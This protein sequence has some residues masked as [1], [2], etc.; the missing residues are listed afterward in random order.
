[1]LSEKDKRAGGRPAGKA[2]HDPSG[3]CRARAARL[4]GDRQP[5]QSADVASSPTKLALQGLTLLV[6][7]RHRER[8]LQRLDL[9][10]TAF[11]N[12]RSGINEMHGPSVTPHSPQPALIVPTSVGAK[13]RLRR[14]TRAMVGERSHRRPHQRDLRGV[15]LA[16]GD[17]VMVVAWF[18]RGQTGTLVR[19]AWFLLKRAWLVDLDGGSKWK[20]RRTRVAE[21]ALLRLGTDD[22]PG[23]TP[24]R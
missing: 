24:S 13:A 3:K 12:Q 16:A 21:V 11:F 23:S 10:L 6:G 1:L 8:R 14:H 17:R 7:T 19:P 15:G 20:M 2:V 4:P 5:P 18:F 22:Q 9:G